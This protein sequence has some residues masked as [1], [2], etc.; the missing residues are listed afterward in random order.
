MAAK[1]RSPNSGPSPEF[2]H[3]VRSFLVEKLKQSRHGYQGTGTFAAQLLWQRR[4]LWTAKDGEDYETALLQFLDPQ[5]YQPANADEFGPAIATAVRRLIQARDNGEKVAIWG[6]FDADGLTATAVLCE[7]L[8]EFFDESH[9]SYTIPNRLTESHGLNE[10]GVR[11]LADQGITVII[12]CDTGS[13]NLTELALAQALGVDVVVTDHHTLPPDNIPALAVINP[14]SLP[15]NHPMATLSGVAVAFKVVEALY[16]ALP[17]VPTQPLENLLD[18]VAIGLIADLVELRGDCRYLAQRGI[19]QLQKTSRLGL[20]HLL[21]SCKRQ[22]DRPTDIS[23]GIGPRINAISRIHGDAQFGVALL[24]STDP[25]ECQKL[26]AETELANSRRKELER[27]LTWDIEQELAYI[28]R[29]TTHMVVLAQAGWAV[30]VLG[31]VAGKIAQRWECPVLLLTIDGEWARG[32]ARSV[33]GL[34]LYQIL[35]RHRHLLHRYGGHPMAAGVMLKT[36][37]IELLTRALNHD[38]GQRRD[39]ID[40]PNLA[41]NNLENQA[42]LTATVADLDYSLFQELKLVEPCGMGNPQP[43]LLIKNAWFSDFYNANIRDSKNT[44]LKYIRTLFNLCDDSNP[45]GCPGL[46]WEHYKDELPDGRCDALVELDFNAQKQQYEVRLLDLNV[47]EAEQSPDRAAIILEPI[48]VYDWRNLS[49]K[50]RHQ[51]IATCSEEILE[52]P[53]CPQRWED[54]QSWIKRAIAHQCALALTYDGQPQ[55]VVNSAQKTY[56]TF[57]G[58]AKYLVESGEEIYRDQIQNKL[59]INPEILSLGLDTL[60]EQGINFQ[61]QNNGYL[62]LFLDDNLLSDSSDFRAKS[63][64][65]IEAIQEEVFQQNYFS[66]IPIQ[67][68]QTLNSSLISLAS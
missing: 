58:I 63:K 55:D 24:T 41:K 1:G 45:A 47:I 17:K 53:L 30:G 34:D 25:A 44:K 28:D 57:M 18:L 20:Q 16:Q 48:R 66:T 46:W 68:I 35:H 39:A 14:R 40:D 37:N 11:S 29:S 33:A 6:D 13:T 43:K 2:I 10:A 27:R 51:A 8:K 21:A 52:V 26:A 3:W 19:Q 62:L 5:H 42:D 31:L 9:L 67:I 65:F 15:T 50:D 59:G 36:K 64:N 54:W 4:E 22:G 12:T 23:F 38:V 61:E 32:S 49:D 56:V 60:K 7:G